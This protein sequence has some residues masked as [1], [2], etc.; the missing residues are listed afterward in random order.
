MGSS[1]QAFNP[2]KPFNLDSDKNEICKSTSLVSP[3]CWGFSNPSIDQ[4][5]DHQEDLEPQVEDS[6]ALLED[7]VIMKVEPLTLEL[8]V[9]PVIWRKIFQEFQEM[10]AQSLLRFL[11]PLSFVTVKLKEVTIQIRRLSA[12][13]STFVAVMEMVVSPSTASSVL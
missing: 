3:L 2:V 6:E 1:S 9:V 13:S 5:E 8:V 12:K 10:I 4:V 11:T 7:L